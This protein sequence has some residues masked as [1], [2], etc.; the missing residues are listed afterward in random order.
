VKK[1]SDSGGRAEKDDS[2]ANLSSLALRMSDMVGEEYR[3]SSFQEL[4]QNGVLEI[5]DG[6]RA[7]NDELGGNG[8][9]FLRAGHVTDT[10]IDF[11]G[12]ERFQDTLADKS[13]QRWHGLAIR[14]SRRREIVP[15][16]RLTLAKECRLLSI[17]H[18]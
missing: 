7:K 17:L 10:H 2:G 15:A 9:I 14:S 12:V 5:G 18:I 16:E 8:P 11:D 13:G 3:C 4:I 1:A 6:Y